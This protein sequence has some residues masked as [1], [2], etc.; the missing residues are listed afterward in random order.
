MGVFLQ[1]FPSPVESPVS[2]IESHVIEVVCQTEAEAIKV[3]HQGLA[4]NA[5]L[6]ALHSSAKLCLTFSKSIR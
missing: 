5:L 3:A 1:A 6:G 4:A 2:L